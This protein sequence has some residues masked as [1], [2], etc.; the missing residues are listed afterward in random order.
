MRWDSTPASLLAVCR[1]ASAPRNPRLLQLGGPIR[2]FTNF[3]SNLYTGITHPWAEPA[4][5]GV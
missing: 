1:G 3:L 4:M 2:P 5:L